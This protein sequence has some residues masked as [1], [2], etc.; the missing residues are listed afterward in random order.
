MKI[1]NILLIILSILLLLTLVSCS[2]KLATPPDLPS[3]DP[4]LT[5]SQELPTSSDN[6]EDT[7][8]KPINTNDTNESEIEKQSE[9]LSPEANQRVTALYEKGLKLYYDRNF[10]D[11]LDLFNQVLAIDPRNYQALNGKGATYAFQGRYSEGISLIQKSIQLKPDFVYAH[12][13]LGLA[14]E[15][16]GNYEES[17]EAYKGALK[18]D[19]KD[20]WSYY[21]I[22]SIYGRKGDVENVL[23]WL[24]PAIVLE[25]EVKA[26]AREEEDFNLVKND[27]RFQ[28]LIQTEQSP[29]KRSQINKVHMPIL[30]YH[31]VLAE[32][33]NELRMPPD[34]F[35][36]QMQYLS[37]HGYR[38][39]TPDQ[40]FDALFNQGTLPEKPVLITFDD[41]YADN[42]ANAF[43]IMKKYNLVG[44]IFIVGNYVNGSGF[45]TVDQLKEVQAAGWTIGGHTANHVDLSKESI[46]TV[47]K[48]LQSSRK[49]IE[50]YLGQ[51]LKYFCYPFGGFSSNVVEKV[52]DDGYL[53]AFT[54]QRGW[55]KTGE[56]S[57]TVKRVY[58][59]ANMGIE[60]FTNRL[61]NPNY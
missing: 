10:V 32:Q 22:A 50:G 51:P 20:V 19:D 21:G 42:Y 44:T 27:P 24:R 60:E 56:N 17:I 8:P 58:M 55:V 61:S 39:I 33:G 36:E 11:A 9:S 41:G 54:T 52:I 2:K 29:P 48:E 25:P 31:S 23:E 16:A 12:F 4:F 49:A 57:H 7:N 6:T 40:L 45:L 14:Y 35:E 37:E 18:L 30:N 1:K 59:Y 46:D 26:V 43:S 47:V 34:Q 3:Q 5:L 15:L 13:N 28:A 53:M 38:T